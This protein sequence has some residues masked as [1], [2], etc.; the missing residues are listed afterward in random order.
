[1]EAVCPLL[2]DLYYWGAWQ[3]RRGKKKPKTVQMCFP[4]NYFIFDKRLTESFF[5]FP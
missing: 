3:R 1:M 5:T 4:G 2:A